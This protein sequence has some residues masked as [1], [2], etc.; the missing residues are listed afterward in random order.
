MPALPQAV[1]ENVLS[2]E[3]VAA[4][5]TDITASVHPPGELP[6]AARLALQPSIETIASQQR[7]LEHPRWMAVQRRLLDLAADD[8]GEGLTCHHSACLVRTK[9]N[10]SVRWHT[11][12]H[13]VATRGQG[14]LNRSE[15]R[16]GHGMWFYLN[17]SHP[18][19]GGL[20]VIENSHRPD[21]RPPR[22]FAFA[23]GR[24]TFH[25][26]GESEEEIRSGCAYKPRL[27]VLH[28]N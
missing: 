13:P 4:F 9:G 21:W 26:I 1:I 20:C 5:R 28:A 24:K 2:P 23:P 25:R 19:A 11:D 27:S 15:T 16:R 14:W 3:Q 17:G 22:G 7:L 12:F 6:E 10:S 18:R 8:P